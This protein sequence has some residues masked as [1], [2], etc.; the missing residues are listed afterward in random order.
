MNDIRDD[1]F[2]T[3]LRVGVP[4]VRAAACRAWSAHNCAPDLDALVDAGAHVLV[5]VAT[6]TGSSEEFLELLL[7]ELPLAIE[8][9]TS[10]GSSSRCSTV[11]VRR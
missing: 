5:R 2:E 3:R 1:V 10:P 7:R 11:E 9:I 8:R 6:Q 4:M